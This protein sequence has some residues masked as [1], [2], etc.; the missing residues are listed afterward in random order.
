MF[1]QYEK[2]NRSVVGNLIPGFSFYEGIGNSLG[3]FLVD[4]FEAIA[5]VIGKF[6]T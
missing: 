2:D 5:G 4:L 1:D 6:K 3:E